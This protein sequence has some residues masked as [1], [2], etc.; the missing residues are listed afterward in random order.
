MIL[1]PRGWAKEGHAQSNRVLHPE[2]F[3]EIV[4]VGSRTPAWKNSR[5]LPTNKEVRLICA[6]WR[7]A[8]NLTDVS[9]VEIYDE[10]F[11][12]AGVDPNSSSLTEEMCA[13][14]ETK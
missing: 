12:L 7:T 3:S 5:I 4:E 2:G 6:F 11:P 13:E 9:P 14:D 1:F 10:D 8:M